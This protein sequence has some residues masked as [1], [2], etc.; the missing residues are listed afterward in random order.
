MTKYRVNT[1]AFDFT[2]DDFELPPEIQQQFIVDC[3]QRVWDVEEED[4][5]VDAITEFYGFCVSSIDYE[6]KNLI[7]MLYWV[8]NLILLSTNVNPTFQNDD[9]TEPNHQWSTV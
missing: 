1:I 9:D 5:L 6:E 7:L 8:K 4:D 3:K 2:D